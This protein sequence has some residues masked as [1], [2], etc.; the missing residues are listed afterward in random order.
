MKIAAAFNYIFG[1]ILNKNK[2]RINYSL[3]YLNRTRN[4]DRNYMDYIR[5]AALE[6]VADEINSKQITGAVAELGV[7]KGKFARYINQYFPDRD[8][9]LF[10]TFTGFD[11]SDIQ[12]ERQLNFSSGE[13]NFSNTSVEEVL[14]QM[15]FPAKCIIKKGYFPETAT[16]LNHDYVFVSIDTDLYEP[17][18]NGLHY[19]Y[20]L[21]KKGG[22]IFVHDYNNDGYIGAKQA[23][24]KFCTENG[25]TK[26]PLPDSCGTAV[27]CK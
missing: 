19:F 11:N 4:I 15:P 21:L 16:G 17:I 26:M 6:L 13:Q 22:Y 2:V 27:L 9:Y 23:V 10:D 7:Y 18:Y 12:V 5:L 20:P 14:K 24:D 8:L 3:N 1:S 25:I